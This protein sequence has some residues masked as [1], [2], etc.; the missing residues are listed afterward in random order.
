M[1]RFLIVIS[2]MIVGAAD[3]FAQDIITTIDGERID[4]IVLE[5]GDRNIRYRLPEAPY[6]QVY[7]IKKSDVLMIGD[8]SGLVDVITQLKYKNLKRIYDYK[9]W[10]KSP[11]DRYNPSLMGFCSFPVPGLGQMI[12]GEGGRGTG[13]LLGALG[14]GALTY[15]GY[16]MYSSYKNDHSLSPDYYVTGV[17]L[18]IFAPIAFVTIDL[19]AIVDACRIAKVKN[20]YDEECGAHNYSLELHPSIDCV[21]MADKMQPTAGL[22]L[23]LRF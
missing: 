15:A 3:L 12:C 20:I 16:R 6:G 11:Y 21:R 18:M 8:Q 17:F 2:I 23:A 7:V 4:A 14:S 5:V 9:E 10:C 19:C 13:F 1:K 22:T